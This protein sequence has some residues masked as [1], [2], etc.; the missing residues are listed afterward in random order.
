MFDQ[1]WNAGR[2]G[3][4]DFDNA[5]GVGHIDIAPFVLRVEVAADTRGLVC[6]FGAGFGHHLL[7]EEL[8]QNRGSELRLTLRFDLWMEC[9]S[10]LEILVASCAIL[11]S[12]HNAELSGNF[13]WGQFW[14]FGSF[15]QFWNRF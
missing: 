9:D 3:E 1:R 2:R 12:S 5:V 15:C 8:Q 7:T 13:P 4:G 10:L 11:F 6:V 14:N